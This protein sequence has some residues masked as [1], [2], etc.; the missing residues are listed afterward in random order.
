MIIFALYYNINRIKLIFMQKSVFF[1]IALSIMLSTCGNAKKQTESQPK[2]D[3]QISTPSFSSDSAYNYVKNQ[4]DFGPRVPNTQQHVA[5][6]NYL[7]NQLKAFGAKVY[8]QQA[9]LMAYDGT[10][11]KS[12]NI[13]GSYNPEATTRILLFAH[14]DTRP[15]A[16]ND[17]NKKNHKTPVLGANDG[18]SGVGVL[19]EIAR[20][21]GIQKPN[22]GVDIA[23]FDSEDYGN[24]SGDE[25][26][27][28]LGTQYWAKNPHIQG[29]QARFGILLDMVGSPQATFYREQI[30]DYFA[31]DVVNKIWSQASALGLSQYFVNEQGGGVTDDHVYINKLAGIPAVDIIHFNKN[32]PSGF[33]SYW[34]TVNDTMEN[35]D[36]NTLQAVGI[37]LM[38]VIYNEKP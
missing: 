31:S 18:A 1:V 16:D 30:S 33:A 17:P 35:V 6:G 32:T 21:L 27:W 11:L 25:D 3:T 22:I 15:W 7:E 29:Y 28:C 8:V 13:I 34:H 10:P 5:C 9:T 4:V 36:K 19:L 26:S 24:V 20:N 38:S 14:W 37:T 23:F 2:V 12:R